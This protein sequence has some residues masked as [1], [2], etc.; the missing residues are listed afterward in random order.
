VFNSLKNTQFEYE[1]EQ[2]ERVIKDITLD[3]EAKQASITRMW[4]IIIVIVVALC[5]LSAF[6][7]ITNEAETQT[8][9]RLLR[10][11]LAQPR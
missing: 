5:V 9:R 8:D 4:V 2:N 7:V 6:F 11:I 3:R 1:M 10:P